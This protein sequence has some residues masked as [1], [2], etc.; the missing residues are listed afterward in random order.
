MYHNLIDDL[1]PHRIDQ[2]WHAY[3]TY[4]RIATPFVYLTALF[5]GFSRRAIGYC[6]MTLLTDLAM[7]AT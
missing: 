4:I 2:V 1:V 6:P 7:A 5:D 3:I